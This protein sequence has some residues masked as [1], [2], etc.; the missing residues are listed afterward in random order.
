MCKLHR[1]TDMGK[2]KQEETYKKEKTNSLYKNKMICGGIYKK[3]VTRVVVGAVVVVSFAS[4]LSIRRPSI[5]VRSWKL[6]IEEGKEAGEIKSWCPRENAFFD[7]RR[8]VKTWV[9]VAS[10]QSNVTNNSSFLMGVK[11]S[12]SKP[13]C[14]RAW[15]GTSFLFNSGLMDISIS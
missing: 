6:R 14:D 15:G 2:N 5:V 8:G 4:S 9:F 7:W 11:V 3:L 10:F 12:K 1:T 13:N